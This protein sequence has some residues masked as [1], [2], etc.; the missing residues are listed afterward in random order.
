[1]KEFCDVCLYPFCGEH[2]PECPKCTMPVDKK[3]KKITFHEYMTIG[4]LR[5][6]PIPVVW[7][8]ESILKLPKDPY[9]LQAMADKY[10]EQVNLKLGALQDDTD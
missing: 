5:D 10:R 4:Y 3:I 2:V 1:M 9:L 6:A 7:L 8:E